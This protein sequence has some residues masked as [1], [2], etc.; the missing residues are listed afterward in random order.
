MNRSIVIT[1]ASN[2]ISTDAAEA[3]AAPVCQVISIV[4]HTPTN[5]QFVTAV[6]AEARHRQLDPLLSGSGS[7]LQNFGR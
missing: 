2:G 5:F 6:E 4:R 7:G 3:L 1:G